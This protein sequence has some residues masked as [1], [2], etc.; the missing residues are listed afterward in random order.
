[1]NKLHKQIL[2]VKQMHEKCL[3]TKEEDQDMNGFRSTFPL[4]SPA[5]S[6]LKPVQ[7][8]TTTHLTGLRF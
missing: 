6:L 3:S 8:P 1:M 4:Q 2:I 5:N 7:S